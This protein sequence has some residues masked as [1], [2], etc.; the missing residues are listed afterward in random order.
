MPPS[1]DV[2]ILR[3][4][5]EQYAA[6][7]A[8]PVQAERRRLWRAHFSL[9]PTRPPV[10]VN[11]GLHNVWC[12]EVFG[13]HQMACEDPFLRGHERALRMAIF[14]DTIGDDF[15]LEPWLVLPAVHDTPSGGW[16]GP[17]GAPDQ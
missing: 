3:D 17:W 2:V 1:R 11:Y 16:G 14:H 10:L 12:R 7:A 6:L 15:I 8:Q 13:D 5:A 9:R 4:L